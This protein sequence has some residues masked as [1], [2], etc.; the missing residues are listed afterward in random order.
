MFEFFSLPGLLPNHVGRR[1]FF[2]AR[3]TFPAKGAC[4]SE[5]GFETCSEKRN[6]IREALVCV[7]LCPRGI[8]ECLFNAVQNVQPH[9]SAAHDVKRRCF[10]KTPWPV[11]I[12]RSE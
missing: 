6:H 4:D 5:C 3:D 12:C 8:T 10:Q 7:G 2:W 9:G 1:T 11:A